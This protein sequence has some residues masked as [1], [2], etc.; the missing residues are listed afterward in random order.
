MHLSKKLQF[1]MPYN[2][3][4]NAQAQTWIDNF[5]C[6]SKC[7]ARTKLRLGSNPWLVYIYVVEL[8]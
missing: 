1:S 7:Q 2:K 5:G 6:F 4:L 3:S 8:D